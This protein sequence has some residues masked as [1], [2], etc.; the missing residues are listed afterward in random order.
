MKVKVRMRKLSAGPEGVRLEG[1]TYDVSLE[2]ARAL[3]ADGAAEIVDRKAGDA[4]EDGEPQTATAEPPE[5]AVSRGRRRG[6]ADGD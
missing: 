4:G 2:E 1:Q 6:P 3:A 5:R